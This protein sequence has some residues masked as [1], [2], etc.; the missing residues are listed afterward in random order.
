MP[1]QLSSLL[2]LFRLAQPEL[3]AYFE[4][5]NLRFMEIATGWLSTM[6]SKEMWLGD[7]LRLWGESLLSLHSHRD[8]DADPRLLSCSG[9]Y[10]QFTLLC[11]RS[12]SWDL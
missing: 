7:V 5:E 8:V 3:Y 9:R 10:V 4:D 6:L 11:L 1:D 12:Y 2:T